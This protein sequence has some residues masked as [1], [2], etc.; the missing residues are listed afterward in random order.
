MGFSGWLIPFLDLLGMGA[1]Q[2]TVPPPA[3]LTLPVITGVTEVGQTLIGSNGTWT[4]SP[5]GFTYQWNNVSTGPIFGATFPTYVPQ[6]SDVGDNLT[7]TVTAH[8]AGGGT[9]AT[10]VVVG[11]VI[12]IPPLLGRIFDAFGRSSGVSSVAGRSSGTFTTAG[13][14]SGAFSTPGDNGSPPT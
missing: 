13:R 7:I 6:S 12:P 4:V 3:N 5:T 8:N 9:A 2:V 1:G 10:S 14:S 11:P